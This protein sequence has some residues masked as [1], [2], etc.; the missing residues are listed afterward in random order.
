MELNKHVILITGGTSGIGLE[1]VK[2]FYKLD[3]QLIVVSSNGKKLEELQQKFPG[4]ITKICHLGKREEVQHLVEDCLQHH[5]D[6]DMLVNN[7]GVQYNYDFKTEKK[8]QEKIEQEIEIN[9]ISPLLLTYGLL[10]LLLNKSTAALINVSSALA[11]TPKKSA[12]VYCATKAGIHIGTKALRYQLEN[13]SV[14]VFEII[15]PLVDTPM[16]FGREA[17]KIS[18]QKLVKEF[19]EDFKD[20]VFES[21]IGKTK[22]LRL[23]QRISPVMADR[24]LKN[25]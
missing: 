22:M 8:A 19:I 21:N 18:P 6:I 20:N 16:T 11:L 4:I 10:P 12:P 14:K 17:A 13:T 25:G 23:I 9:L 7:A 15:P 5:P 3:N 2:R 1:L 24:I